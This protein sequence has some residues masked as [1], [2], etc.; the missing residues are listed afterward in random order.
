MLKVRVNVLFALLKIGIKT[1]FN[2]FLTLSSEEI[3]KDNWMFK[4]SVLLP[5]AD[6]YLSNANN[7]LY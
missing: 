3:E 6:H 2:L 7:F 1:I 5:L 4:G